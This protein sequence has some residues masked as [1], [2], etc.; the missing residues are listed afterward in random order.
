M[1]T[2]RVFKLIASS[3]AGFSLTN[4]ARE[5]VVRFA[6]DFDMNT[7]LQKLVDHSGSGLSLH[8]EHM[9]GNDLVPNIDVHL[10]HG[11]QHE[12]AEENYVGSMGLYG[13]GESSASLAENNGAGQERVFE[14]TP[15]FA[16]MN[17]D[18]GGSA[19]EFTLTLHPN[20]ALPAGAVLHIGR[21][22]LY[23]YEL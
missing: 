3:D 9:T 16:K 10:N 15:V 5:I 22:A 12:Q 20:P 17:K 8:L 1:S 19:T 18:A 11:N 23:Y 2:Y 6:G 4:D 21:V 7:V 13:L 14:V